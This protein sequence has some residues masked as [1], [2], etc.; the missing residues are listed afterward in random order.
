MDPKT[1]YSRKEIKEKL[2][3]SAKDREFSACY[4]LKGFSKRPGIL[5]FEN[6]IKEFVEQGG[7]SFHISEE[8]WHNPLD[9]EAGMGQNQLNV[10]RK[11]WDLILDIDCVCFEYSKF[12]A[13]LL[14]EALK[15]NDVG[16]IS[17]KFSGN[18]G[19]HI[20]V[21]FKSFPGEIDGQKIE[22]IFPE[23][24]RTIAKYLEEMIKDALSAKILEN[25]SVSAIELKSGKKKEEFIVDGK[26]DPFKI[27]DIDTVLISNR[28]MFRAPYSLHEKSGL[29]SVPIPLE[30]ALSF[31][32]EAARPEIVSTSMNFLDDSGVVEGEARQLFVQAFDWHKRKQ[33]DKDVKREFTYEEVKDQIPEDYFPPC[34]NDLLG[35][36]KEDG[37]KRALFILINFFGKVGYNQEAIEEK[38]KEWNSRNAQ[39]LKEGYVRS[40]LSWYKRNKSLL[41]PNCDNHAYYK[42]LLVCKPDNFCSK[43]KNPVHYAVKRQRLARQVKKK[44]RKRRSK[45]L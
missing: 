15:F 7:T 9:L 41:P 14:V 10:L 30:M 22:H 19:M 39:P 24:A 6:D 1:Y 17:L 8:L 21:P 25:D 43:I 45:S 26:F 42:S 3:A 32:K 38:I 36:I 33:P 28:H 37:R 2:L 13:H 20:G 5:Q 4:N 35:G 44:P 31:Q 16:S 18:K 27:V 40:Q 23:G 29:V 11:G 34:I 12:T